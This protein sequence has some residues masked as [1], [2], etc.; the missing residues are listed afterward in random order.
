[1]LRAIATAKK[2]NDLIDASKI[3]DC[4]RCDFDPGVPH[5][6]RSDTGSKTHLAVPASA[7]AADGA[8]EEPCL[9]FD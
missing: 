9:Q 2:K 5:D 7:G 8:D 1:M 6:A 3:A 4:L